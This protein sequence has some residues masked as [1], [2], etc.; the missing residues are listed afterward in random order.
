MSENK[1]TYSVRHLENGPKGFFNI[2]SESPLHLPHLVP[3]DREETEKLHAFLTELLNGA[4]VKKLEKIC[5]DKFNP[6]KRDP[7]KLLAAAAETFAER[8]VL[9]GDNYKIFG[10]VLL[11]CFG[12]GIPAITT[13]EDANRLSIIIQL[14]GKLTRYC[15]NFEEGGHQDSAHDGIVYNAILEAL[16]K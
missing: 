14:I 3:F 11:A 6:D 5:L 10:K 16:T 9:Y 8:N 12:G 1:I 2:L 7:A 13:V 15:V 4:D